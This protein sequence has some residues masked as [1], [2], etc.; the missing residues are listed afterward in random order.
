MTSWSPLGKHEW[1]ARGRGDALTYVCQVCGTPGGEAATR[2]QN[3]AAADGAAWVNPHRVL[4]A[5][6]FV[7]QFRDRQKRRCIEPGWV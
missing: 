6:R 1:R 2:G 3:G 5:G 7:W 4:A